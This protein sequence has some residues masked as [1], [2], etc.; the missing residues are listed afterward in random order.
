MGRAILRAG[1]GAVLAAVYLAVL[2]SAAPHQVH[3]AGERL[4]DLLPSPRAAH[5]RDR[6]HGGEAHQHSREDRHR[7]HPFAP[8]ADASCVLEGALACKAGELPAPAPPGAPLEFTGASAPPAFSFH[9]R[10]DPSSPASRAPP[11]PA[12]S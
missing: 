4:A 12:S 8:R 5:S 2:A 9:A 7:G 3:H 11:R 10:S 6:R 1:G